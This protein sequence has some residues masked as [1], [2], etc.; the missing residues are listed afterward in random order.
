ML[1][2]SNKGNV[3]PTKRFARLVC[4]LGKFFKIFFIFLFLK[5]ESVYVVVQICSDH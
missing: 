5:P 2:T 1:L 3:S 4:I